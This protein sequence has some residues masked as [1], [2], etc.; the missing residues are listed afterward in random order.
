MLVLV[1]PST[2]ENDLILA[3]I[4]DQK[5]HLSE[6]STYAEK[7]PTVYK[8]NKTGV[9]A[10]R[11]LLH[12]LID[13]KLLL[14]EA[15][16]LGIGEQPEFKHKVRLFAQALVIKH[17]RSFEIDQK[18]SI[19]T[20]EMM[21]H[22]QDSHR[23]RGLRYAGILVES[24]AK[25]EELLDEIEAGADFGQLARENSLFE[26]TRDQGGDIGRYV[27]I[28]D[29]APPLKSIFSMQVGQVSPPL[30]WGSGQQTRYVIIKILDD[31]PVPFEDVSHTVQ[32][33]VYA[34]NRL[35]RAESL[36]DSL[37][38]TYAPQIDYDKIDNV[39]A[40]LALPPKERI[41]TPEAGAEILCSYK[42]GTI[43]IDDF[44]LSVPEQEEGYSRNYKRTWLVD[45]LQE[46]AIPNRMFLL[47]A[48]AKGL[49]DNPV[50]S[51]AIDN[52]RNNMLVSI[53]RKNAVDML[54]P[55][56][57]DTEARAFYDQNPE[58]FMGFENIVT[59]EI[60]VSFKE[61]AQSLKKELASGA[62]AVQLAT[63]YTIRPDMAD[64]KGQLALSPIGRYK[65]LY[66]AAKSIG[67]GGIGGPV[68]TDDGY[69]VFKVLEK[70]PP[71]K[72]PYH[73]FSQRRARAYVMIER[74]QKAYVKYIHEL[75]QKYSVKIF[76]ESL[77]KI[78]P[79]DA[80]GEG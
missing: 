65:D 66:K 18:I 44:V 3:Q 48:Q 15:K 7:I 56:V 17:Y 12:G 50:V 80:T 58:K 47:E 55:P 33:E 24:K 5:I 36:R 22:F 73:A 57:N 49:Y 53:L 68:K 23:D 51:A 2:A 43:T 32:E 4:G 54:I 60:L 62:D 13:K 19:S 76:E 67:V 31:N 35:L 27:I 14:A 74:S 52:E 25:A 42:G 59:T 11:I 71:P 75:H 20:E 70:H 61:Q 72:K 10:D 46:T 45:H 8:M 77:M 41:T 16:R 21:Q 69:S 28:D 79:V 34:K 38:G 30:P 40:R 9:E 39:L 78:Q 29:T 63:D 1:F 37:A 26:K 6:F 64:H